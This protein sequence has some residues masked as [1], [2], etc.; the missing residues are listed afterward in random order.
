MWLRRRVTNTAPFGTKDVSGQSQASDSEQT[1]V[2]IS[3]CGSFTCAQRIMLTALGAIYFVAFVCAYLQNG[4]LLG[5]EGLSPAR[6]Y[7]NKVAEHWRRHPSLMWLF[8]PITDMDGSLQMTALCGIVAAGCMMI[9]LQRWYVCLACWM[10]Y[11]TICTAAEGSSFYSYGWESQLLETG[12]LGIFLCGTPSCVVLYLFRWLSFRISIGAGLIKVRG[13]SCW[14]R[15][16][17][18]HSHF[19]TQPI[20]SPL[21]F[22]FHFMPKRVLSWGVDLDLF[23]QLYASWLVLVP[24][25]PARLAGG[26]LQVSFMLFIALSGNFAFLNY[27]TIIP[28]LACF[29]DQF[30][31]R[32]FCSNVRPSIRLIDVAVC[33]LIV[34]FSVPVVSNLFKA[35]QIMNASFD[36]LRLVNTYGAFGSVSEHRFEPIISL[37]DDSDMWHEIDFPCK[38]GDVT[39]RPCFIAPYHVR[40]DW[41][42]W[43]VG[44]EPHLAM[45]NQRER[46]IYSLL[47][48]LL[49]KRNLDGLAS[50]LDAHCFYRLFEGTNASAVFAGNKLPKAAKVDMFK[51]EMA[52][53]LWAI[54]ATD[55]QQRVW[56]NRSFKQILVPPVI[57]DPQQSTFLVRAPPKLMPQPKNL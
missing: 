16:T 25:R 18:L 6:A 38:P 8:W 32:G 2:K 39:R 31:A 50:V 1:R 26:L 4:E 29:D 9:G 42:I 45:L 33:L 37:L 36:P 52:A 47:A 41:N 44:F 10:L 40:L 20:P 54:L 13:G 11:H 30:L 55:S 28:A 5:D 14:E 15:R 49:T 56:W 12:F 27:L 35:D 43:F 24:W 19:E 3:P 22:A 51:Y 57:L 46:W 23:V 17:C 21:S 34:W 48:Q 7:L 53:P